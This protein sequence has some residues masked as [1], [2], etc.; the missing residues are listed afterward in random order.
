MIIFP[1]KNQKK[2]T[3]GSLSLPKNKT[4]TLGHGALNVVSCRIHAPGNKAIEVGGPPQITSP[5]EMI[6]SSVAARAAAAEAKTGSVASV[7]KSGSSLGKSSSSI[8][9]GGAGGSNSM[10]S[11]PAEPFTAPPKPTISDCIVSNCEIGIYVS[12]KGDLSDPANQLETNTEEN[13]QSTPKP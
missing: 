6:A 1:P 12:E 9:A 8:G 13:A 3:S 2:N 10:P 11:G 7:T 4:K 5:A